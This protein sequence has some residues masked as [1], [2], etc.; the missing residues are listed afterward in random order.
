M[1]HLRKAK[2]RYKKFL[3]H[4]IKK[5]EPN[6]FNYVIYPEYKFAKMNNML[7]SI[8]SVNFAARNSPNAVVVRLSFL[9][10]SFF[11]FFWV[12]GFLPS[13]ICIDSAN[14]FSVHAANQYHSLCI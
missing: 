8:R 3:V 11:F 12:H 14:H 5:F 13:V 1:P 4:A 7:T 10:V 2:M 6:L 9:L